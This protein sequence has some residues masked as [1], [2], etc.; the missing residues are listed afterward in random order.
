[1]TKPNHFNIPLSEPLIDE[2]LAPFELNVAAFTAAHIESP[3]SEHILFD[4]LKSVSK[5]VV[6]LGAIAEQDRRQVE[7]FLLALNA[8]I[9]AESC[10]G[11]RTSKK[12]EM[13]RL[14]SGGKFLE[15]HNFDS[16]LRIGS[17]PTVK[18]WRLLAEEKQNIK[19]CSISEAPFS[20]LPRPSAFIHTDLAQFFGSL[21]FA[22]FPQIETSQSEIL[23]FDLEKT[24]KLQMLYAKYP[25]AEPSLLHE[26]SKQ[27]SS[28]AHVYL[29]NSLP[30][31]EWDLAANFE[32]NCQEI[33]ANRGANGID[34]QISSFFGCAIKSKENWGIFGDLTSM[35]DLAAPYLLSQVEADDIKIVVIN[36]KGGK[37]FRQL[38]QNIAF[39][40]QHNFSFE[41]H[42][43][44]WGLDYFKWDQVPGKSDLTQRCFI[45]VTPKQGES[46]SFWTEY[47]NLWRK[48]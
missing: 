23:K 46:D 39:E 35:Y 45:E 5:P 28:D 17:V 12:L 14:R 33:F 38:F 30:I 2:E 34:G 41:H 32:G 25:Q 15:N 19:V 6:I 36:N 18:Y 48:Y 27:I 40:N 3:G 8:P 4:F 47:N 1:M 22:E 43:K 29:G 7:R 13:L 26:L 20:G 21:N 11:L 42:A 31:R 9:Y 37:I 24:E 16:V 10:S 44:S